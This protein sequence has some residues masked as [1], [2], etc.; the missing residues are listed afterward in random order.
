MRADGYYVVGFD[1]NESPESDL[2]MP[3]D[4]S[5]L[6]AVETAVAEVSRDSRL[7]AMI[8]NAAVQPIGA[9]GETT[10]AEHLETVQVNVL[11]ADRMVTTGREALAAEHGSIV[12]ISSVHAVATTRGLNAYATSKAALEGWVRSAALD[13][14]P[15]IRVNAVRPGAI[16]TAK[17]T[18]GFERWG[19][20]E[21]AARRRILEERTALRR[22]GTADEVAAA[23]SFLVGGDA[24]FVTGS[25]LVVDGG[26]SVRLGSE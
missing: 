16:D 8:H 14:A 12:V 23:V 7:H 5:D 10:L 1:R 17:L 15:H 13:L 21:G 11:A 2:W 25:I 9:A 24:S 6:S 26:A 18:E 4:L 20:E 19:P 22:V 3:V